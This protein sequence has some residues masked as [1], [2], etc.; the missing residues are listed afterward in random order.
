MKSEEKSLQELR[1]EY[2]QEVSLL[3]Q[4]SDA[5]AMKNIIMDLM[6]DVLSSLQG[7]CIIVDREGKLTYCNHVFAE[8]VGIPYAKLRG[9]SFADFLH[10]AD[11]ERTMK[12][13]EVREDRVRPTTFLNRYKSAEKGWQWI[14]WPPSTDEFR[15]ELVAVGYLVDGPDDPFPNRWE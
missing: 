4:T 10:P 1:D 8:M 5:L 2:M 7:I 15:T 14:A 12:T 6:N 13:Y 11:F 3:H 9:S